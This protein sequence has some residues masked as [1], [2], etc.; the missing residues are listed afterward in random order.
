MIAKSRLIAQKH[1]A[2]IYRFTGRTAVTSPI[3]RVIGAEMEE[4]NA[5]IRKL[6]PDFE[7]YLNI[8]MEMPVLLTFSTI[9]PSL[10]LDHGGGDC[11]W[12]RGFIRN[13]TGDAS[14]Q[15]DVMVIAS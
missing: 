13:L 4:T 8:A 6:F 2:S 5:I 1:F 9:M 12:E 14:P 7:Q 10:A 15:K 11:R 3:S